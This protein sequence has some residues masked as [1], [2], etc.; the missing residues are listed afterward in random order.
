MKKG[1]IIGLAVLMVVGLSV[2]AQEFPVGVH[3]DW[4]AWMGGIHGTVTSSDDAFAEFSTGGDWFAGEFVS[5][6]TANTAHPYMNV[7]TFDARLY[8]EVMDNGGSGSYID[9]LV[10]RLDSYAGYG[11]AGQCS[12][13]HLYVEGGWGAMAMGSQTNFA[14]QWDCNYSNTGKK[15]DIAVRTPNGHHFEAEAEYFEMGKTIFSNCLE[16]CW[17]TRPDK[18]T[19]FAAPAVPNPV[20]EVFAFG[21]G[22]AYLDCMN[23][24]LYDDQVVLGR[25]CGCYTDADFGATGSG[26]FEANA[27]GANRVEL[28]ATGAYIE[29]NGTDCNKLGYSASWNGGATFYIPDYSLYAK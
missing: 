19:P 27:Y 28:Y 22:T 25:G 26:H 20:A 4:N 21:G 2:M 24:V 1:L 14:K 3:V 10:H 6:H 23:S 13:S 18:D 7:D 9:L 8:A 12:V 15:L 16:N 17:G 5:K 29:G 11:P